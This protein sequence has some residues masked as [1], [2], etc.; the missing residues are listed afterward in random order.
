M[1]ERETLTVTGVTDV[2]N[3]DETSVILETTSGV[4]SVDGSDLHIINL[5]VDSGDVTVT[6]SIS[7]IIYPQSMPKSSGFL[8]KKSR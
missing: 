7:G 6:G 1:S 5:N 8:R 3:F 2:I 4:M